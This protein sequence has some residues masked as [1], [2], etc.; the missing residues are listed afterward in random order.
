MRRLLFPLLLVLLLAFVGCDTGGTTLGPVKQ[1]RLETPATL[2]DGSVN[3][4]KYQVLYLECGTVT[5]DYPSD[6]IGPVPP[7]HGRIGQTDPSYYC[8]MYTPGDPTADE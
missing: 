6:F 5:L 1:A 8:V 3:W 2:P 7:G 4:R